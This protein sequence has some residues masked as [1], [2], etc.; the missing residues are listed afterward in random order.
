MAI[1]QNLDY[2]I[3]HQGIGDRVRVALIMLM[4]PAPQAD[5]AVGLH[6]RQYLPQGAQHSRVPSLDLIPEPS[7]VPADGIAPVIADAVGIGQGAGEVAFPAA[8]AIEV[9][10]LVVAVSPLKAAA[11]DL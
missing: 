6:V 2:F 8:T 7:A 10:L 3:T 5:R 4:A 11:L 9:R 1:L